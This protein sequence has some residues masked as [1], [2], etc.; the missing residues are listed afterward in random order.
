MAKNAKFLL[1]RTYF[2]M[3]F[4]TDKLKYDKISQ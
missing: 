4:S 2:Y 1:I 3:D